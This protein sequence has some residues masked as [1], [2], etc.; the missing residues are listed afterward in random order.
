[1]RQWSSA[2]AAAL[3]LAGE[4]LS[5]RLRRP[6][7]AP[8]WARQLLRQRQQRFDEAATAARRIAHDYGNVLTGILGFSELALGQLPPN[9]PLSGYLGEIHR[10]ALVGERL[11]NTLRLCTRRQWPKQR[12]A[13]LSDVADDEVRRVGGKYPGTRLDV[14]LPSDLPPV[15]LDAEPLR[16]VLTQ[17]LDNAAEAVASGGT[18]RLSARPVVLTADQCLDLLGAAEPGP[19]VEVT[20]ED[21]GCGL[22]AEARQRLLAE[23]FFT[24][25]TRHRGYGLCVVYGVLASHGGALT[26]EPGAGGGTVARAYLPVAVA[27]PASSACAAPAV[28]GERVLVVDDDPM[29]LKLC[30]ATLEQAGYRVHTAGDGREALDSYQ[31]AGREP[32]RLVVSDVVMPRMTGVDLARRLRN[33]DATLGVVFMS[34]QVGP[35]PPSEALA[36]GPCDF[37]PKP[38]RPEGLLN[39][40]RTA[41]DRAARPVPVSAGGPG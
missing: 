1:M 7:G 13:R 34:G 22:S 14:A 11:T 29:I 10:S 8:R 31:A 24:T 3:A 39:A 18:V 2:E 27:G 20:V 36:G 15:A 12:P 41:L 33:Q 9:S 30:S 28:T 40:V 19:H 37:L 5:R 38:F 35:S 25:K 4:A 23:P 32:F 26:V 16:H 6:E 21:S 17:L